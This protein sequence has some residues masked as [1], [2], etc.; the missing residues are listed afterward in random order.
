MKA[1]LIH[2]VANDGFGKVGKEYN[3][4]RP[5]YPP[6]S[7]VKMIQSKENNSNTILLLLLE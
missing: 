2:Q 3:K 5:S 6:H 4:T 1:R 7:I